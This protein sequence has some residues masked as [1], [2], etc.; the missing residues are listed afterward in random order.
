M[1]CSEPVRAVPRIRR[2]SRPPAVPP[3]TAPTVLRVRPHAVALATALR[4]LAAEGRALILADARV[5]RACRVIAYA[6][7][8]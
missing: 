3:A 2:L 4:T 1:R 8:A 6:E 7:A 5:T